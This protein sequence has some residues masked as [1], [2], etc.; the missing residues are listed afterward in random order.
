MFFFSPVAANILTSCQAKKFVIRTVVAIADS[1]RVFFPCI[2]S[3]VWIHIC[4]FVIFSLNASFICGGGDLGM[5]LYG[6]GFK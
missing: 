4:F 6:I 2:I 5:G 3:E 1:V